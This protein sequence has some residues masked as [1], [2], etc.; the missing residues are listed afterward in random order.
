MA[1]NETPEAAE[2][3]ENQPLS[4][5]ITDGVHSVGRTVAQQLVKDGHKVT[6]V[7][8]N[9]REAELVRAD[10]SLPV[11]ADLTRMGEIKGMMLMAEATIVVN[12]LPQRVNYPPV[13]KA[14]FT[15]E[16]LEATNHAVVEAAKA[17]KVDFFVQTSATF[18]YGDAEGQLVDEDSNTP[19]TDDALVEAMH[20]V[21]TSIAASGLDYCILRAGHVYGSSKMM[22]EIVSAVRASRSLAT[23][24]GHNAVSWIHSDDLAQAVVLALYQQPN[25]EVFN[26]VDDE[27][28]T[29]AS[30]VDALREE[31]GISQDSG[32]AALSRLLNPAKA[33]KAI[34]NTS[35]RTG[36]DKIRERLGWQPKYP[37][38]E[39]G[40]EYTLLG[41][42]AERI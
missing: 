23:G 39:T 8:A 42:R 28:G 3:E 27:P 34:L 31:L 30:F 36:N 33:N 1:E 16:R 40:I 15:A 14:D 10:G 19:H 20:A 29:P 7:V 9:D 4:V 6:A 24:D 17:A 11:Y 41:W 18:L 22:Q 13:K 35:Y 38:R 26:V 5:F 32:F 21:E 25:G 37:T 2:A 12:V